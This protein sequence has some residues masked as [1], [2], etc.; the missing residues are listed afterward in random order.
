M[1]MTQVLDILGSLISQLKAYSAKVPTVV[2]L[3]AVPGGLKPTPEAVDTFEQTVARFRDQGKA[4]KFR[5]LCEVL[6]DT[7][8]A[9]ES[10]ALLK[11]VQSLLVAL[12]QLELM[13]REKSTE[14][15]PADGGRLRDYRNTLHKILPGKEPELKGAGRGLE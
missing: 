8:E 1:E 12:D 11:A 5:K 9:F 6:I 10:G 7:L 13:Q 4:P 14:V 3:Q 15:T 2:F